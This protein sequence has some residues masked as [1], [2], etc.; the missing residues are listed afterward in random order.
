MA[1]THVQADKM[2][3]YLEWCLDVDKAVKDNETGMLMHVACDDPDDPLRIS[4]VEVYQNDEAMRAHLGNPL[5]GEA[6]ARM[7]EFLVERPSGGPSCP[8]L[9]STRILG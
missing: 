3:A 1:H 8:K 5:V 4:W 7:P 2:D 6:M 9:S